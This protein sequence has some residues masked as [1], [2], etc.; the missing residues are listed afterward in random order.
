MLSHIYT[1]H[2]GNRLHPRFLCWEINQ[3][4][5]YYLIRHQDLLHTVNF[6]DNIQN[7]KL[8][9]IK[10][11]HAD[12]MPRCQLRSSIFAS[13]HTTNK[14]FYLSKLRIR[15]TSIINPVFTVVL[16]CEIHIMAMFRSSSTLITL[17]IQQGMN[18]FAIPPG[19][20]L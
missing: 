18:P 17:Y 2:R 4:Y 7:F 16:Y 8:N 9:L 10:G 20:P 14:Y 19:I 6:S 5:Y 11:Y 1:L 12:S 13:M 3:Y 15:D